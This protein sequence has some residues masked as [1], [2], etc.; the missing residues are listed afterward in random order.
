G[1]HAAGGALP[2]RAARAVRTARARPAMTTARP[3]IRRLRAGEL[4]ALAGSILV[5]VSMFVPN[6]EGGFTHVTGWDTFGVAAPLLLLAAPGGIVV[7]VTALTE[8][9]TA[10]P[11]AALVW[12]TVIAIAGV[13]AAIV[14]L[15]ERPGHNTAVCSGPWLALA[16]ALLILA[17]AWQGMRDERTS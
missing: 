11:V 2:R 12:C 4:L 13:I 10:L 1:Q 6:Y 5:I 16:G 17:G 14:R 15:L 9:S 3:G 7:A 8:R